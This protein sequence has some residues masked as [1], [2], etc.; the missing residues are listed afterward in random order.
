MKR[1]NIKHLSLTLVS[2]LLFIACNHSSSSNSVHTGSDGRVYVKKRI[3]HD[4]NNDGTI[5]FKQFFTFNSSCKKT[6]EEIDNNVDAIIDK[7]TTFIYDNSNNL[8]I[9]KYIHNIRSNIKH[10]KSIDQ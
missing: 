7:K 6:L 4:T 9:K 2:S 3:E 1:L 5:N 10:C 8:F